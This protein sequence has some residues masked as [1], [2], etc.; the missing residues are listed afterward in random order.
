[1]VNPETFNTSADVRV[2][3]WDCFLSKTVYTPIN[4]GYFYNA[5]PDIST[6]QICHFG[7][8]LKQNVAYAPQRERAGDRVSIALCMPFQMGSVSSV[9]VMIL[10]PV[11]AL[12]PI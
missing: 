10:D 4:T 11:M 7:V 3:A 2:P 8:A 9:T 12:Y 5:L 6:T 1:M